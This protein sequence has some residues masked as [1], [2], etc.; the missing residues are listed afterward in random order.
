[1][2]DRLFPD[3]GSILLA[4]ISVGAFFWMIFASQKLLPAAWAR[5]GVSPNPFASYSVEDDALVISSPHS[6]TRLNWVGISE[7]IPGNAAWLFIGQGM[8]Y[9][10][11]RRFFSE[12]GAEAAFLSACLDRMTAEARALSVEAS[13]TAKAA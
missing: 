2:I 9:F 12:P 1:M 7:I 8:A 13:R 4:I 11:P 5:R 6:Q 3:W 10:L